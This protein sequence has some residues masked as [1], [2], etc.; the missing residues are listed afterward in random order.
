MSIQIYINNELIKIDSKTAV[1]LNLV[2]FDISKIGERFYNYTNSFSV[3]AAGNESIFGFASHPSTTTDVP[4]NAMTID[5]YADGLKVINS[6]NCYV[7]YYSD[8]YY[9][10][11]VTDSKSVIQTMKDTKLDSTFITSNYSLNA[12]TPVRS[13]M[14][15]TTGF[16]LDLFFNDNHIIEADDDEYNYLW[17]YDIL[18]VYVKYVF[19]KFATDNG[20]TFTGGLYT[21][22]NFEKLR[23]SVYQCIISKSTIYYL[24]AISINPNKSFYDLFKEVLKIFCATYKISGNTITI[25]RLDDIDTS[26]Y[27]DWSDKLIS[28]SKKSFMLSGTG[29]NNYIRYD[30]Q[31]K[32]GEDLNQ[33]TIICNNENIDLEKEILDINAFV[34]PFIYVDGYSNFTNQQ[35]IYLPENKSIQG[36]DGEYVRDIDGF[37]FVTDGTTK[38][39]ADVVVKILQGVLSTSY[40]VLSSDNIY[41]PTYYN[42]SNDYVMVSKMLTNTELYVVKM[43]INSIDLYDFNPLK[44]VYIKQLGGKFYVN[45]ISNRLLNSADKSATV[46]LIKIRD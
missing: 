1:S 37:I 22:S 28:I 44:L 7:E 3:P 20:F 17:N 2:N 26:D 29:Q 23:M 6:G 32:A 15:A 34:Y 18:T 21:D 45:K 5:L 42:S 38:V 19:N 4:Y 8:G 14:T 9:Y 11:T 25:S 16:K 41:F 12:S 35:T 24:T 36:S 13:L 46:E 40:T 43:L 30:N 10:M 39:P 27:V 31:E 33:T